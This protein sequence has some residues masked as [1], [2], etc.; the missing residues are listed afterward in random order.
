[1]IKTITAVCALFICLS[2]GL[3]AQDLIASL[4]SRT[5]RIDGGTV[6]AFTAKDVEVR[7][8][9]AG[10][11][12]TASKLPIALSVKE[13]SLYMR[14][15]GDL[16]I[17]G[18][19]LPAGRYLA[20]F[21]G[22]TLL[23]YSGDGREPSLIASDDGLKPETGY[24]PGTASSALKEDGREYSAER[25]H[26]LVVGFPWAEGVTGPG[27]GQSVA[28]G[29]YGSQLVPKSIK[30]FIVNGFVSYDRPELFRKNNRVKVLEV[31]EG[32]VKI[33][34]IE[35]ADSTELQTFDLSITGWEEVRFVI[36][37]VFRGE[38]F[39]DTCLTMLH[40]MVTSESFEGLPSGP[41]E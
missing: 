39:D 11:A 35:L 36:K 40:P 23:L 26:E 15:S 7:T 33:A 24:S 1:M 28:L 17:P 25:L 38:R 5:Y 31:F 14:T 6:L 10:G 27:I 3:R 4:C 21:G 34:E 16:R 12:E 18:A 20:V 13:R 30:L 9:G 8:R 29:V 2:H 22:G 32:N 37:D 19:D 41:N